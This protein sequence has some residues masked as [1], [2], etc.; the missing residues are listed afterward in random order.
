LINSLR[1]T[2]K[3]L[4]NIKV[5]IAGAGS[6][7]YGIFKIL[8]EAGCKDI[9]VTDSKGAIY[10][11]RKDLVTT[12]SVNSENSYKQEIARNSNPGKLVG[13]L[14]EVIRQADV[15]IGVSGKAGLLGKD[16]V[17]AM[18]RNAIVFGLTNPDPEILPSDALKAGARIVCTGRSDF[19]NQVNNAVVFPSV[20][21]ALLDT[22]AKLLD[23]DML[24][25]ASYAIASLVEEAHL[26]ED[27]VIPNVNDPRI[28]PLVTQ[29]LK[30][31]IGSD[32]PKE[33]KE[34]R[35]LHRERTGKKD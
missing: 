25:T 11:A 5:I 3:E 10:E 24:V 16:M 4:D 32:A 9:V 14:G 8:K 7:G 30:D 35:Q 23:E 21:R 19:P 12:T 22:R 15:F 18:N 33:S 13:N 6:A 27:Y 17:E 1:I 2:D 29:T 20:L 34:T 31:A 28:L 26:K